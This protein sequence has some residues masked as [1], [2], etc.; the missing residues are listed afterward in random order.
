MILIIENAD[1]KI[2]MDRTMEE[3]EKKSEQKKRVQRL[4]RIIV[5]TVVGLIALSVFLNVYL[6]FRVIHLTN[7]V[8]QLSGAGGLLI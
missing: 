3:E 5:F 8:N 1:N 7:L 4:K 2:E 6:L